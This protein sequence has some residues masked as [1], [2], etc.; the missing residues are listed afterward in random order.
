MADHMSDDSGEVKTSPTSFS[1]NEDKVKDLAVLLAK[2]SAMRGER[3]TLSHG[4]IVYFVEDSWK[5]AMIEQSQ[6]ISIV[7]TMLQLET[8]VKKTENVAIFIPHDALITMGG[9]EKVCARHAT[10]K[11]FFKEVEENEE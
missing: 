7:E 6:N 1:V 9:L 11:T 4:S 3:K 5:N 8:E 2:Q 10:A